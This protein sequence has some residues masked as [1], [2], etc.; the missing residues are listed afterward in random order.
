VGFVSGL[1]VGLALT[2]IPGSEATL[3]R[4]ARTLEVSLGLLEDGRLSPNL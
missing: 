1:P 4:L 3:L 2:G